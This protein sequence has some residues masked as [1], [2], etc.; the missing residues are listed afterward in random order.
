MA[1]RAIRNYLLFLE[2][3]RQLIDEG[4]I[5]VLRKKAQSTV[6][7]IERL[8]IYEDLER[9]QSTDDSR[10]RLEFV[11]HAKSWAAAND[12]GAAAFR[13]LGVS[14]D[15]LR[16]AGLLGSAP[17]ARSG[18]RRD[19]S[20]RTSVSADLIKDHVRSLRGTFTMADVQS[21]VGG[22]PMTVRKGVQALVDD[23]TISRLGPMRG[24]AGRGRAPIVFEVRSRK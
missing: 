14:D 24:W 23:G 22:S 8:R 20:V 19:P 17:A 16:S 13:H 21:K 5:E 2:D 9:A 15:V 3:P 7:P 10:Y 12:V 6:D 1:E 18:R 4:Q 11:L